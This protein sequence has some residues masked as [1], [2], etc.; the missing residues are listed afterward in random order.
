MIA[1]A[2][3]SA[4]KNPATSQKPIAITGRIVHCV[5]YPNGNTKNCSDGSHTWKIGLDGTIFADGN[6][7]GGCTHDVY[8]QADYAKLLAAG[9]GGSTISGSFVNKG[10][11]NGYFAFK[12]K[13]GQHT[14]SIEGIDYYNYFRS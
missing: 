1:G 14:G 10:N 4:N 2:C 6:K 9:S 11:G 12:G 8:T 5:V 7:E 13:T 3:A